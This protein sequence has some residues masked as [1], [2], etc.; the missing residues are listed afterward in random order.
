[1]A[2]G[3]NL[4]VTRASTWGGQWPNRKIQKMFLTVADD[5]RYKGVQPLL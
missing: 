5:N 1:L 2:I 3:A 4:V